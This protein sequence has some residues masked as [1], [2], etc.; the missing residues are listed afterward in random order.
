MQGSWG[1]Q[2]WIL[3]VLGTVLILGL[4]AAAI[5]TIESA[6]HAGEELVQ[7]I[8]T[9]SVGYGRPGGTE[10]I[11]HAVQLYAA[12]QQQHVIIKCDVRNAF[13]TIS[14][15]KVMAALA[16]LPGL[17]PLGGLQVR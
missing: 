3:G 14:R 16:R 6:V 2:L 9:H 10:A 8:G 11:A 4:S 17:A 13:N 7:L 12:T 1:R 15:A 5:I